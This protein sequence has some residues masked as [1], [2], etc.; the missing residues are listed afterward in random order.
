MADAALRAGFHTITPYLMTP[1]ADALVAFVTQAFGATE[2]FRTMGAAGGTHIE[3]RI[4]DS[5]LMIGGARVSAPMPA[6]LHLYVDDV[7]GVYQ[8]ALTAG[9]TSLAEPADHD[10][11]DRRGGVADRF[12]NQWWLATPRVR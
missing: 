9:G 10:D 12:G 3:V 8:R 2:T 4:G 1:E 5:M 6:A 7:D 11:G